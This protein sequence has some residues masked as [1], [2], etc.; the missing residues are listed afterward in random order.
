MTFQQIGKQIIPSLYLFI[1]T[2]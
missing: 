2:W 1:W